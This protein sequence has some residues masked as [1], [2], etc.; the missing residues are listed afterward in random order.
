[1]NAKI[2]LVAAIS[3]IVVLPGCMV[4]VDDVDDDYIYVDMVTPQGFADAPAELG[5]DDGL[6]S[7]PPKKAK[8]LD[9]DGPG[10]TAPIDAAPVDGAEPPVVTDY[11][12]C[13]S[14]TSDLVWE[15]T[16]CSHCNCVPG[17][18]GIH[19]PG[20]CPATQ[21]CGPGCYNQQ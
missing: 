7:K 10:K 16:A 15:G 9:N 12:Y 13:E 6:E 8:D 2:L 21:I 20:G 4:D 3:S 17:N 19:C 14:D 11:F 5:N 18:S 1:M